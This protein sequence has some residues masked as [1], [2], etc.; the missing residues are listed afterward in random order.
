M[1]SQALRVFK[2]QF[3][4]SARDGL[5]LSAGITPC[6]PQGHPF[7]AFSGIAFAFFMPRL[8]AGDS[9]CSPCFCEANSEKH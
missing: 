9:R 2:R 6:I 3:S 1:R 5:R 4:C 7:S 8:Q